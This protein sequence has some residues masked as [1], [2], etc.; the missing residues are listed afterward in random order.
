MQTLCLLKLQ[1]ISFMAYTSNFYILNMHNIALFYLKFTRIFSFEK[2]L[3]QLS[4][5]ATPD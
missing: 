3:N 5:I 1:Q 4:Y 2:W